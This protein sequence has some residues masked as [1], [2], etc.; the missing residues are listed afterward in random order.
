[1][2]YPTLSYPCAFE[3]PDDW[4]AKA[5]FKGFRAERS[6]YRFSADAA[7]IPVELI[8]QRVH[9]KPCMGPIGVK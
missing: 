8:G 2:R 5:G 1:M 6:A 4:I 3:I 7:L 9:R